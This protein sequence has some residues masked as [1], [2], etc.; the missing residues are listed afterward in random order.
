M[1]ESLVTKYPWA[2]RLANRLIA[3]KGRRLRVHSPVETVTGQQIEDNQTV[4]EDYHIDAFISESL[5]GRSDGYQRSDRGRCLIPA[6]E[7]RAPRP[8]DVLTMANGRQFIV[9]TVTTIEPDGV[10]I[11]Y[12]VSVSD[13]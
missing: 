5:L 9:D 2:L 3:D 7:N 11:Y 1:I 13:G 4:Y 8:G 10:P 12:D 6:T